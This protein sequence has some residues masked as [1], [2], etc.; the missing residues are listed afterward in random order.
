MLDKLGVDPIYSGDQTGQEPDVNKSS[1]K[2][3]GRV[4][5]SITQAFQICENLINDWKKGISIAARITA[6]LNGEK[7]YNQAKLKA[8]GKDWKTNISTGFLATECARVLPRL[9]MPIKT[10]KYL[11]AASLPPGWDQGTEKTEFFRQVITET[12]RSWPQ[13]NSYIRGLAREVGIFGFA[14][15]VFFDE[16]TTKPSLIRMDKGFVPQGTEIMEEPAFFLVKYDYKPS[17]LLEL[18]KD[19]ESGD[20][21]KKQNTVDAINAASAP[22]DGTLRENLR[23]YEELIR[24][25]SWLYT[26]NKGA[27]VIRTW[28]LFAQEVNGK[29]S[30]YILLADNGT[31]AGGSKLAG[32]ST[33]DNRLLYENLDQ[34]DSMW[35]LHNTPTFD[36][37]DGTVHG[38]WGAGQILY[39][40]AA[41]VEKI[42]CDSIDN[43]RM[44]NKVKVQVND[45]KNV[46]DVK[47]LVNDQMFVVSGA[48]YAGANAA[49]P[50]EVEGYAKLDAR[51]AQLAQEKIGAFV[52]PIPLQ[53]SDI[54]AAQ[55]N[56][57]VAKE[58]ELQESLLE[59]WLI[60]FAFFMRTWTRRACN[61]KSPDKTAKS[62]V[63]RLRERLS[64]EEIGLL[65]DQNPVQS[66]IDFTEFRSQ[67][68][69]AFAQSVAGNPLFRQNII[70]RTMAGGVG[71][72][73]F[74]EAICVPEGDNSDQIKAAHDQMVENAA[75]ALGMPVPV[76]VTDLDW[77][78]MQTGKPSLMA[79][80]QQGNSK[81]AELGL[82]HYA[83]HY[84]QGVEKK[85]V[86]KE[87]IN[88]EKKWI[89]AAEKAIQ[90]LQQRDQIQQQAQQAHDMA[91]Q[92]AE[93]MVAEGHPA[94][95]QD[96][97]AA[98]PLQ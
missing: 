58:K 52:P 17:E 19:G 50:V 64:D 5:G 12:V 70:A 77:V 91:A 76:L 10:A 48:T 98:P 14:F 9:Y 46:N 26:Y 27:K 31:P 82:Q 65:S 33:N 42:R 23:S 96:P 66:V 67:Q 97:N 88:E 20:Y 28:H 85:Q 40:L 51:L 72:Q 61:L 69:A 32:T 39:D 90:A 13:F 84:A 89:A 74:V 49:M 78:H 95:L 60:H 8:G 92:Q 38:S 86:P 24:Q 37:G 57:A 25:A 11:T 21:W 79:V 4:V 7:P 43:L 55:I 34:F 63:K 41:Q 18:L 59:N 81:V 83:A 29:V 22:V 44:T 94:T 56:A 16:Y 87:S 93:Q 47:L 3:E 68:K 6:K 2:S 36:Y 15:N 1:L 30:H 75:L 45:A 54:K 62:L 35:D 71:D 80:I 73:Q 53:P